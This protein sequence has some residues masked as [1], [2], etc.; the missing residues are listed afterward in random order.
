MSV[1]NGARLSRRSLRMASTFTAVF[2]AALVATLAVRLWLATRQIAHV[3]AHRDATPPAFAD[4][5]GAAAHRKAADYT[6]AKQRLGI[7]ETLVDALVLVG[8]TLGGGLA[9]LFSATEAVALPPILRDLL[10]L[11]GQAE[12]HLGLRWSG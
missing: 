8:I 3:R 12:I 5:V 6:V 2:V 11:G 1:A 10:L 9:W 4:R 7:A